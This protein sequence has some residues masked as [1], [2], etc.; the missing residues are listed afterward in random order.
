MIRLIVALVVVAYLPGAALM[1]MPVADRQRRERLGADERAYWGIVISA[2]WS[3]GAA[4]VLAL[5]GMY[6]LERLELINVLV[7]LA[8]VAIWRRRL[9]YGQAAPP[10]RA[11][12]VSI[13]IAAAALWLF[14]P[15]SEYII[16]GKDPGVYINAGV[17][18][19]QGGNLIVHDATAA[20]LPVQMRPLFFPQYMD[21]TYYSPRFMGFFLLD[22]DAGTVVDQFPHLYPVAIAI[23]YGAAGL[24]GAREI[25]VVAAMMGVLGLYFLGTRLGGRFAGAVAA[26]LLAIHVAQVWYARYPNSEM[27]TQALGLAAL[28]AVARAHVDQD[29]FFAPVAAV[30]LGLLP[31][32]RFDAILIVGLAAIGPL[33]QWIGGDKLRWSFLIPLAA[34]VAAFGAYFLTVIAPYA[35]LARIWFDVHR[36][37]IFVAV[38]VALLALAVAR[39]LTQ[40]QASRRVLLYWTPRLLLAAALAMASYAWF[41]RQPGGALAAHDAFAF[42]AFGWY[43]D[44]RILLVAA[45]GLS[46]LMTSRFWLDPSTFIVFIGISTFVFNRLRIVPEHFWAARR[47]VPII[48]PGMC[49]AVAFALAPAAMPGASVARRVTG[50]ARHAVRLVLLALIAWSFWSATSAIRTHVEFGGMQAHLEKLASRFGPQD[51]VVVESRNASDVHVLGL[52]LAYIWDKPVLVLSTPKPDPLAFSEFIRWA[53]A[54]YATVYFLGGGGTDLLS[55]E[56]SVEPVTGERFQVREYESLL[57]AYPTHVRHKEFDYGIY[58]FVDPL[59]LPE[60]ISIDIG[61]MDDLHVVRFNAKEQDRRGTFRWTRRQSYLSLLGIDATRRQLVIWMSNGNRPAEAGP[62]TVEAFLGETSLGKVTVG[63]AE[64]PYV[65]DIPPSLAADAARNVGA[66]TIRL[67][68]STFNPRALTGADDDRELGVKVNRVEL[69]PLAAAH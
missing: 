3:L 24:T 59:P 20:G 6:R 57:N 26:S 67:I 22:P 2:A 54:R 27:L 8:I 5:L 49:L 69:R 50:S 38:P 10:S 15:P 39:W 4:F 32:A 19:A 63:I 55:R 23:G 65:F 60:T 58:R 31:F 64:Q 53:R 61:T 7:T 46:L 11:A 30:T 44:P 9:H 29:P 36:L 34:L 25:T 35:L 16:G 18:I 41:L 48:L 62:A 45:I 68:S 1:R 52:P 37:E 13:V 21:Q 40:R 14:Q 12:A 42:R 66:A 47:F 28:L 43:V 56:V 17:Q 33:L 51:L